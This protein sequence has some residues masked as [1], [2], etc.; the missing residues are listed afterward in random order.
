MLETPD[1]P[2]I[3][4]IISM[5]L[6]FPRYVDSENMALISKACFATIMSFAVP[7]A[8]VTRQ[9]QNAVAEL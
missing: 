5:T 6:S 7:D 8:V 2:S 4:A 9:Q 3:P 1:P